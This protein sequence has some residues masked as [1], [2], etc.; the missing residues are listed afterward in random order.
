MGFFY[1]SILIH[2]FSCYNIIIN[3]QIGYWKM[4]KN[5]NND[6]QL[7]LFSGIQSPNVSQEVKEEVTPVAAAVKEVVVP[8]VEAVVEKP[9]VVAAVET[10]KVEEKAVS[11]GI[12]SFLK[13]KEAVAETVEPVA[14]V[15][16]AGQVK[17]NVST[18]IESFPVDS[19][20]VSLSMH[21][22]MIIVTPMPE[23]N[24][25]TLKMMKDNYPTFVT[26][27]QRVSEDT[28]IDN[29]NNMEFLEKVR[30]IVDGKIKAGAIK[31]LDDKAIDAEL[32]F[33]DKLES[34]EIELVEE[35]TAEVEVKATTT[36][37]KKATI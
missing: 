36:R 7:D 2:N 3:K 6:N 18:F 35:E 16:M 17:M 30:T 21:S 28:I 26:Q 34:G 12:Q 22:D 10:P 25:L 11:E 8:V 20:F 14:L 24:S 15:E 37:K 19:R 31:G 9:V 23:D 32:R 13:N 4:A 29:V 1:L 27:V 33:I 5:K